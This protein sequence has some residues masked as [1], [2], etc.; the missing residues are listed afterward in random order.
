MPLVPY[1]DLPQC[2]GTVREEV[3]RILSEVSENGI[4]RG[5]VMHSTPTYRLTM[6]HRA[7]TQEELHGWDNWWRANFNNEVEVIWLPDAQLYR[8][9]FDSGANVEYEPHMRF[10]VQTSILC[11]RMSSGL[12]PVLPPGSTTP[13]G[14]TIY[15]QATVPES[16]KSGDLWFDTFN[17]K[18]MAY[19]N[20]EWV[21]VTAKA[22]LPAATAEGQLLVSG[23][24]PS[25][26]WQVEYPAAGVMP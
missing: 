5:R 26:G 15:V 9:I 24:A 16:P 2:E 17:K 8:G 6:T 7:I 1:P 13:D 11:K 25:F 23:P 14:N 20:G 22:R 18:W 10:T 12:G 21:E 4:I 19:E 3:T